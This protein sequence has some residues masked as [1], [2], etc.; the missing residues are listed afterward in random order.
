[1]NS[2]TPEVQAVPAPIVAPI[3]DEANSIQYS[4]ETFFSFLFDK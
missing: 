4:F 3:S 1:V 2:G